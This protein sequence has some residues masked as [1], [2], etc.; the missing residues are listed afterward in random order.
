MLIVLS[1]FC[2]QLQRGISVAMVAMINNGT[3]AGLL[4]VRILS[5]GNPD[6]VRNMEEYLKNR[7]TGKLEKV[8]WE[9]HF[10]ESR[11]YA[12]EQGKSGQEYD[13]YS[14]IDLC[15]SFP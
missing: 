6:L 10:G 8:G 11:P 14:Y 5:A 1:H 13:E 12:R 4:A 9:S 15:M 2:R 7:Q 3:N